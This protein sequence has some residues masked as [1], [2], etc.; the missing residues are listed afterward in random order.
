[1]AVPQVTLNKDFVLGLRD[2]MD[3]SIAREMETTKKVVA[4]IPDA[5]S[6]EYRPDPKA[7]TAF[8]AT[9]RIERSETASRR[10][11]FSMVLEIHSEIISTTP[12][13]STPWKMVCRLTRVLPK[14]KRVALRHDARPGL[15]PIQVI[16]H[17]LCAPGLGLLLLVPGRLEPGPRILSCD[18]HGLGGSQPRLLGLRLDPVPGGR[19]QRQFLDLADLQPVRCH[20][21]VHT[22][23]NEVIGA[24]R[25]VRLG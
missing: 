12:P 18:P 22:L 21:F 3:K 20:L 1:M 24:Q 5:R 2:I 15:Q 10:M 9:L 7:R 11:R 23:G 25:A 14:A 13:D 17:R 8:E 4:A 6:R 19:S 16:S